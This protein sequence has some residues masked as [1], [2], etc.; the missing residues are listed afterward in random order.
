VPPD[1]DLLAAALGSDPLSCVPIRTGGHTRSLAWRVST[2]EGH[3]F[4]KQAE[5]EGSLHMLRREAAVYRF[6]RGPFLPEH[7]GFADS[8]DRALLAIELLEGAHWPPP[9]PQDVTPL[10]EALEAVGAAEPPPELPAHGPWRSRWQRVAEDPEP[11][12]GLGLCSR[13]WLDGAIPRLVE[14]ESMSSFE[15]D[16]LVHNDVYSGNVCFRKGG[17]LL[18]DWGAA[19]RG[20]RWVDIAFAA[21]SVRVEGGMPSPVPIAGEEALV[22]ALAGHFAVEATAPLPDWAAP[23]STLREAMRGDLAHLLRWVAE[24]LELPL[25]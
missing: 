9:Y 3:V 18:V 13:R 11:L 19:V 10:F 7:V 5:D 15:G 1:Q 24:L 25:P 12:L 4:V 6:V 16:D 23:D 2:R 17:T 14:A 20:S 8:G 21:L 22:A